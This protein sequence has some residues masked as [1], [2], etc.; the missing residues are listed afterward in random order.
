MSEN[1]SKYITQK[2]FYALTAVLAVG[3]TTVYTFSTANIC[4]IDQWAQANYGI[5]YVEYCGVNEQTSR[6]IED[7]QNAFKL[8]QAG[9]ISYQDGVLNLPNGQTVD[10]SNVPAST[11][12]QGVQLSGG[13]LTSSSGDGITVQE[14]KD[15]L[16][17]KQVAVDLVIGPA[18]QN[19][20]NGLPGINGQNGAKGDD[21]LQ[22]I[23]GVPGSPGVLTTTNDTNV[24]AS[25]SGTNLSLGWAGEL[26]PARGGTGLSNLGSAG[27]VLAVNP[28]GTALQYIAIPSAPVNS[29]FGRT[30][31]VVAQN[32]D[33]NTSLVTE[34]TNLY[35]TDTR[36]DSRFSA[37]TTDDLTE[38]A[39]NQYFTESRARNSL[40][41]TASP[42]T[43]NSSTGV[44]D[45]DQAGATQ[46]GYLSAADWNNFNTVSSTAFIQNGNSFGTIATLGT[47]DSNDL[48]FETN[49][50]TRITLTQKG[51]LQFDNTSNNLFVGGGNNT[52][53]SSLNTAVGLSALPNV[54][55]GGSNVALGAQSLLSNSSGRRNVGIGVSALLANTTG[56]SNVAIGYESFTTLVGDNNIAIGS[57][58]GTNL[59]AG[60]NNIFIG[61]NTSPNI[62]NTSSNQLNIGNWIYGNIGNIGIGATNPTER[63]QVEGSVRFN[64]ALMPNNITGT[65]GQMLVSQ[66]LGLAP[67]WTTPT[68]GVTSLAAPSGGNANGGSVSG[69][70]LTLSFAEATNP[71]LVSTTSQIFAGSK[72]FTSIGQFQAGLRAQTATATDDRLAISIVPGGAA[73]F[74]GTLTS[75]DLTA[76]R[77]WTL[78]DAS[79]TVC[80]SGSTCIASNVPISALTSATTTNAINNVGFTQSWNWN[81]L[82]ANNGLEIKSNDTSQTGNLLL[83]SSASTAT[84]TSGLVAFNFTGARTG[85]NGLQINDSSNQTAFRV[86]S[87]ATSGIGSS[88]FSSATTTG[89][90]TYI[91]SGNAALNST[92]GLLHVQN[93]GASTNGLVLKVDAN[94]GLLSA[95]TVAANGNVGVGIT[96][97]ASRLDVA[98]SFGASQNNISAATATLDATSFTAILSLNGAQTITL[99][100]ATTTARRIYIIT[101]PTPT[102]KTIT[103]VTDID[104]G[105]LT[106]IQ[107]NSSITIQSDGLIW[108]VIDKSLNGGVSSSLS[109]L[110]A[111]TSTNAIDNL[112]NAQTWN[113]STATTQ[114]PL[115]LSAPTLTTGNLLNLTAGTY[116]TGASINISQTGG[117]AIISN[118]PGADLTTP[119][120]NTLNVVSGTTGIA[121]FDSGTTGTVNIGTSA[122]AKSIAI[123]NNA[124]GAKT[125][126]IG[127][128]AAGST[129]QLQAAAAGAVTI[130][131][132]VTAT[133]NLV[134]NGTGT[135]CTI[136]SGTGATLCTSDARL[137]NSVTNL[138][139]GLDVVRGLRPVNFKWN[140]N[141]GRADKDHTGFIAQE[142]EQIVPDAVG[143]VSG[144]YKGVDYAILVV[145]AIQA[146]KE[147]D[148]KVSALSPNSLAT[149]K[150]G[151]SF[152]D[153]QMQVQFDKIAQIEKRVEA[154]E[155]KIQT[156]DII[157]QK[158]QTTLDVLTKRL[159]V[160]EAK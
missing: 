118:T 88:F 110:T 119:A 86:N 19:G 63:L 24:T 31:A 67:I 64:G 133:N 83:V 115:S 2:L 39:T 21:G 76:A 33:Y 143:E 25:L 35:Y 99:P 82:G 112:S 87:S 103:S 28:A 139:N 80:I 60:N 146:I 147:L 125:I 123:G 13:K 148:A 104:G 108:R 65:T 141:L 135:T 95:L 130:G 121:T 52:T 3:S 79:G 59:T 85:G 23:V 57:G 53:T 4:K 128:T 74:D 7:L 142:V 14:L 156:Q 68:I 159:D 51:R 15:I 20:V 144:G 70:V 6:A 120:G 40:S 117:S 107:P 160:L 27:Q 48:A 113:W 90:Q 91:G 111:A 136:G 58:S 18:G 127:S 32:G 62:G 71:G 37:Q 124:T 154:L 155:A 34:G 102:A 36:F 72:I 96:G 43:Y 150:S 30:G 29:L 78:P 137:K 9:K 46:P 138:E 45:I 94:S 42:L 131:T 134:V 56:E 41:V 10:I 61:T 84:P 126:T 55:N 1:S 5:S 81:T 44:F 54:T 75:A 89:T 98:G 11:K 158:Q 151:L 93:S 77:T 50:V 152:T 73:R 49:G 106:T 116:T 132:A 101:N 149:A 105:A 69:S 38:G 129:L 8:D 16:G 22:G 100:S 157:I 66:G 109:G 140:S 114:N 17:V 97:T 92:N 26:D 47:N 12:V 153:S 122:N 145:P